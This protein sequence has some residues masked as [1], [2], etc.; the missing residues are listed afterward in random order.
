MAMSSQI[1]EDRAAALTGDA[2]TAFERRVAPAQDLVAHAGGIV[3]AAQAMAVRFQQG[4]RLL[5]FGM[6]A[7]SADAQHI[8]VEFVH[9]VIVGK[10]AL[11]ALSLASD[12]ATITAIAA[13]SGLDE[14][15]AHQIRKLA[16]PA[17]L[18]LGICR[19]PGDPSV[20]GGLLAAAQAGLLTIAL[21]GGA[22]EVGRAAA[23]GGPGGELAGE[24]TTKTAAHLLLVASADPCVIKEVQVTIYHLLWELVHVFFEQ[25]AALRSVVPPGG[26]ARS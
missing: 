18:A 8:A 11:P 12:I 21:T 5:T 13:T 7:A 26:T 22:A 14:I 4:G 9:P 6:G 23:A 15:F 25:P 3:A 2:V 17:D 24:I 10:R 1:P 19:T 20:Q 16:T